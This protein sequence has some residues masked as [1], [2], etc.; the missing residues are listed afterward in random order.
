MIGYHYFDVRLKF[1]DFDKV[2]LTPIYFRGCVLNSL[3]KFFGEIGGK[4]SLDIVKF[5]V[6]QRRVVFRVPE[7]F[8][9]RTHTVITLI[10]HYQ[11]VPCHFQVLKTSKTPLDFEKYFIGEDKGEET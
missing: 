5:S 2:E 9:K 10:G 4:T 1:R 6:E 7:E 8:Y 11:E 3:E